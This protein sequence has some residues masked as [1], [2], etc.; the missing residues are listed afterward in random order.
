MGGT[1]T[2]DLHEDFVIAE[3]DLLLDDKLVIEGGEW[4]M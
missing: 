1:V 3:P 4:R 2:A